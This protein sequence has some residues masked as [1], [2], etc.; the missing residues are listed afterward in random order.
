MKET[1]GQAPT[2]ACHVPSALYQ[3]Q[4][5]VWFGFSPSPTSP[6]LPFQAV[7]KH[8]HGICY[9]ASCLF[10]VSSRKVRGLQEVGMHCS[11]NTLGD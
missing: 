9:C 10:L 11:C 3:T 2:A 5:L 8:L 7:Q 6:T 1:R 4:G